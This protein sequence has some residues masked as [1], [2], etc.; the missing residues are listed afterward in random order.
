M[1]L[2]YDYECINLIADAITKA[3]TPLWLTVLLA[4]VPVGISIFVLC[5]QNK[6]MEQQNDISMLQ[7]RL[8]VFATI[9]Q[10]LLLVIDDKFKENFILSALSKEF[11]HK[12][13][14]SYTSLRDKFT[15]E[16]YNSSVV[17]D[18][19]VSEKLIEASKRFNLLIQK[20]LEAIFNMQ[21]DF[22]LQ[23]RENRQDIIN[24]REEFIINKEIEIEKLPSELKEAFNA[25]EIIV[26]SNKVYNL[27]S[28]K[29]LQDKINSYIDKVSKS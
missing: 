18:S 2:K 27:L 25:E 13:L 8:K 3:S 19:E 9:N 10:V 11:F 7:Y 20:S 28:D 15:E 21:V 1:N 14:E 23:K 22:E 24:K 12:Q 16:A 6:I 4:L 17:F 5:R 26:L 29:E